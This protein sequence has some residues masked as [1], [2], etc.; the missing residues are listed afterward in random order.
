MTPFEDSWQLAK[1]LKNHKAKSRH[2]LSVILSE[3]EGSYTA[4]I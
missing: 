4:E 3:A 2:H 1:L